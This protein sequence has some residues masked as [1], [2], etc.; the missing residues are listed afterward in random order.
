MVARCRTVLVLCSWQPCTH[1]VLE[2]L[3]PSAGLQVF[4]TAR[5]LAP[6]VV[7]L[8]DIEQVGE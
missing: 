3:S 4:K 1:L 6:S 5:A 7:L 8:E 2:R